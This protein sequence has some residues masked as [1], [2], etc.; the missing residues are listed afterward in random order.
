MGSTES[1]ESR[2]VSFGLDEEE[3]V[4]V[5]QGI[6]LSENVVNRMKDPCQPS[7]CQQPSP[8]YCTCTPAEGGSR[9]PPRESKLPQF[10]TSGEQQPSEVKEDLKRFQQEQASIQEELFQVVKREREAAA[11]HLK[12]PPPQDSSGTDPEKPKSAQ[13]ARELESREAEQRRREAFYREQLERIGKKNAEM[14]KL[15]SQQFHEAATKAESAI[16]PRRVEPV[17][18]GLQAQILRCYRE[19]L[20]EVLRCSDLVKAYQHCVSAH[21]G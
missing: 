4:R 7:E 9:A 15:S 12:V 13:L 14:Y 20:S 18:S 10:D 19:H 6:R 21:K 2:R 17:C 3:R 11:K 1:C 8:P 16:R 5:L